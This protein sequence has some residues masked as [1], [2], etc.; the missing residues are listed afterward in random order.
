MKQALEGITT[1]VS[2]EMNRSL[3]EQFSEE[4]IKVALLQMHPIKATK[5][6]GL[7]ACFYQKH[8]E[9]LG[10]GVLKVYLLLLNN[11]GNISAMNQTLIVLIPKRMT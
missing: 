1:K 3:D 11:Q 5:L 10:K 9:S 4:E 2:E 7:S 6:Y 8:W